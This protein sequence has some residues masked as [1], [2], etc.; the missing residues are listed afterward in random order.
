VNQGGSKG[1]GRQ[2]GQ[3][4]LH[5]PCSRETEMKEVGKAHLSQPA[6]NVSKK[7]CLKSNSPQKLIRKNILA[8]SLVS[9]PQHLLPPPDVL[10]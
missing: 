10:W 1:L 4:D 9:S 2:A 6:S 8:T 7:L 3:V 5:Q